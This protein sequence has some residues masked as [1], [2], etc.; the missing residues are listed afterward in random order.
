MRTPVHAL[1]V[2]LSLLAACG[3]TP[4]PTPG[5]LDLTAAPPVPVAE[6]G[7][8]IPATFACDDSLTIYALFGSDSTGEGRAALAINDQR[9]HLPQLVAASGARYGDSTAIFWNK[10]D[11]ATFDWQGKSRRCSVVK[12]SP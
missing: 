11:S 12:P 6:R 3:P 8:E 4:K 9:L 7:R 10:G 5:K 1:A 2:T